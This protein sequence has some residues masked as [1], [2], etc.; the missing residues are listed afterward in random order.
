MSLQAEVNGLPFSFSGH[1]SSGD[2]LSHQL[3]V[4]ILTQ[5]KNPVETPLL[6]KGDNLIEEPIPLISHCFPV[7]KSLRGDGVVPSHDDR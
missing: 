2:K 5:T 3:R 7:N 1:P 6:S 4:P